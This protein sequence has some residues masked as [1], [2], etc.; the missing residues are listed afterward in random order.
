MSGEGEP[1][2][3]G[4]WA[5]PPVSA[6]MSQ[7]SMSEYG[8]CESALEVSV[9]E[10]PKV[11]SSLGAPAWQWYSH[12]FGPVHMLIS[13]HC[14]VS[15]AR[16]MTPVALVNAN[17]CLAEVLSQGLSS[18]CFGSVASRQSL[19]TQDNVGEPLIGKRQRCSAVVTC[20]A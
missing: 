6:R 20:C 8:A 15:L 5:Q 3:P 19:R 7:R 13:T 1:R 12:T 17:F 11:K 4:G 14:V 2:S 16:V 18:S 9:P 10:A